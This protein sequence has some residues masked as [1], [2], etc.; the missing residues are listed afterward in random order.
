MHIQINF[1]TESTIFNSSF[2]LVYFI[3]FFYCNIH[4]GCFFIVAYCLYW[5]TY[6]FLNFVFCFLVF[7]VFFLS[8]C[9][10]SCVSPIII[11]NNEDRKK[12]KTSR[13]THFLVPIILCQSLKQLALCTVLLLFPKTVK[14]SAVLVQH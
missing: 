14:A 5:T 8:K 4:R 6:A 3:M 10:I 9:F 11:A 13:G 12:N 1:E 2:V 7:N